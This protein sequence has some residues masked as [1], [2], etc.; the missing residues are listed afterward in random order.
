MVRSI[1]AL[2]LLA[3]GGSASAADPP[4]ILA[5]GDWSKPVADR[6]GAAVRGRLVVGERPRDDHREATLYV[7][8]QDASES[9]GPT[10]WLFCDFGR[11]DFRPDYKPGLHCDLLDKDKR[12]VKPTPFPF[13][14][15]VPKSE[16]VT[17]PPDGTI[18]LRASPFGI[19]R[20]GALAICPG[21]DRLWVIADNDP[22]DY[23]LTGTFTIEPAD[24]APA[25]GAVWRGTIDLPPARIVNRRP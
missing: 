18:R 6:R 3:V 19:Y 24:P 7:E 10:M 22:A 16:W 14:G 9:I 4:K 17:L 20:P 8:L 1:A 2:T 25:D 21:L 11:H 23:F 15:A 12:P 5:A 13:G